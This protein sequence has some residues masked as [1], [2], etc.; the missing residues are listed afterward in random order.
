MRYRKKKQK[1]IIIISFLCLM[2][3]LCVGYAAFS[4]NL[5]ITAKGNVKEKSRVI[6]SWDMNS[7]T[8]F[9]SDFYKENIV[10]VTFID[11]NNVPSNA[12]ESWN[13]S[14][15]KENGGVLAWVIPN[16]NDNTK[17]DLYIGAKGGVIANEDSSYLFY[18]FR[19]LKSIK[20]NNFNTENVLT[21]SNMFNY[22]EN[23]T[24]LDVSGFNTSQVTDMSCMF[25]ALRSIIILNLSNFDTHNVTNMTAMFSMWDDF[26]LITGS[27]SLET[28][29]FGKNFDTSK[30]TTMESMFL[31]NNNLKSLNVSNFNTSNVTNMRAMFSHCSSL[32]EL[33]VSNFDTS[34]VKN[35]ST[36]FDYLSLTTLDLSNFDTHNV[37]DMSAMFDGSKNLVTIYVGNKW[38]TANAITTSMFNNCGTNS[39]TKI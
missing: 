22:C 14:E 18:Y 29:V 26:A 16:N 4:T 17:Y 11:N 28:I 21:M 5:S 15:D 36:M 35:M 13:V 1:K 20:F 30:V 2:L 24:Q 27:S 3:F 19:N 37:T 25:R 12:T 6:Q 31:G 7:Q 32:S 34:K 39:V 38:S 8:D 10:S 9:H 23:L 33:N